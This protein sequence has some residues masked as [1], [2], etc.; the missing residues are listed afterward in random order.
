[1][2]KNKKSTIVFDNIHFDSNEELQFYHWINE[3]VE[4]GLV[5][6]FTYQPVEFKLSAEV[7]LN[8]VVKKKTKDVPTVYTLLSSHIYT[9]DFQFIPTDKF[10]EIIKNS[11][12]LNKY[13]SYI[14]SSDYKAKDV[15]I[16]DVKGTFNMHGGDRIFSVNRKW[17]MNCHEVFIH[18]IVPEKLFKISWCPDKCRYTAKKSIVVKKFEDVENVKSFI[19][20]NT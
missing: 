8:K 4:N 14:F 17:V 2:A 13:F 1:M 5:K 15:V 11:K 6:S 19:E 16:C 7:K 3:A 18:K 20:K 9:P 12:E 10:V